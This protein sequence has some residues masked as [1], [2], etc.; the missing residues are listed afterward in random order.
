MYL[1]LSEFLPRA[2][3][4]DNTHTVSVSRAP[5]FVTILA[6][7]LGGLDLGGLDGLGLNSAQRETRSVTAVDVPLFVLLIGL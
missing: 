6:W 5:G 4:C 7:D 1:S 3:A 2:W